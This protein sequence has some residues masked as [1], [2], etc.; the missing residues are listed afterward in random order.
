[1]NKRFKKII[2]VLFSVI[3]CFTTSL[4]SLMVANAYNSPGNNLNYT[5]DSNGVLTITGT[6]AMFDFARIGS[7]VRPWSAKKDDI[8][9]VVISEGVTNI[10]EYA[11][12][13][14]INLTEVQLP[15]TI[16]SING[17]GTSGIQGTDTLSYG[18][19]RGC[20]SLTKINFPSGL[21][22]IETVAFRECTALKEIVLPDSLT[23][24][25]RAAFVNCTALSKVAFGSGITEVPIECF[26]NCS[27]LRTI[28]WGTNITSISGWAFYNTF[29]YDVEVPES[30][31]K[32]GERG[33]ANCTAFRSAT[34]YNKDCSFGTL[35]FDNDGIT[36]KQEL[37][38][39]GYTG[40]TA[41]AYAEKQGFT[42]ESIDACPHLQTHTEVIEPTCET[43]GI[44]K[45]VCADCGITVSSEEIPALGH[46]YELVSTEDL[47]EVNAHI[48]NHQKCSRCGG[49]RDVATHTETSDSTT[50]NKK[51]EWVEGYYTY[52][53]NATCTTPGWGKY[54]CTVNGCDAVQREYVSASD[55]TVDDWNVTKE[56]TCEEE[57]SK[58]GHCSVCDKD[59]TAAIPATGHTYDDSNLVNSDDKSNVDGHVYKT[60]VCQECSKTISV[61]E[62][63]NWIEGNY[64]SSAV[65][66]TCIV[67]GLQTD[68]CNICQEKRRT[69]LPATGQHDWQTTSVIEPT[70]TVAGHTNYECS[71]CGRTKQDVNEGDRAEALGHDY[72]KIIES[73]TEPNCT[74]DGSYFYVCQRE[75]CSSSKTDVIPK[76]GHAPAVDYTII[77]KETCTSPGKRSATCWR[78]E[79]YYEE[80][81]PALG[82]EFQDSEV[83]SPEHPGHVMAIPTCIHEGCNVTEP[84]HLKHKEWVEGHYTHTVVT[85]ATCVTGEVSIDRCEYCEEF[86]T[87]NQGAPLGHELRFVTVKRTDVNVTQ[88]SSGQ[89]S[90]AIGDFDIGS[91]IGNIDTSKVPEYSF[92]YVCK[93]CA[94]VESAT[95]KQVWGMWSIMLYNKVADDRTGVFNTTYLDVNGDAFVNAK[96]YAKIKKFYEEWQRYEESKQE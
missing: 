74:T 10:G 83:D 55:H 6:G 88:P 33:F 40:S 5:L 86:K 43:P 44:S 15:S 85:E 62:H 27:S 68:T 38:M 18:A 66:P 37:T 21:Q 67:D 26:Y 51:Y 50:I 19:F 56:P 76:L 54:T 75:K 78:C 82:H 80:E 48:I 73:S 70:C 63:V 39:R 90:L 65:N 47:R 49:E 11:F 17:S 31:S 64:T 79:Q 53:C 96:D 32:I 12:A 36:N 28:N 16:K 77:K 8:K 93:H 25:G 1:M 24:I 94:S 81:V 9:K 41:Q 72:K 92:V 13:E 42:F 22:T 3:L 45:V 87:N 34:V 61:K 91:I 20:T 58:S 84:A 60:Y 35:A 57:G 4:S 30:I 23:S 71:Q 7:K 95:A 14:C 52:E 29:V 2:A 89:S 59:V 69:V 46:E